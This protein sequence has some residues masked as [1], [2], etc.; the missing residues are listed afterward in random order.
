MA[1][2]A[3]VKTISPDQQTYLQN[4]SKKLACTFTMADEVQEWL[5][6]HACQ[7][8]GVERLEQIPVERFD[9]VSCLLFSLRDRVNGYRDERIRNDH[10]WLIQTFKGEID[11][12]LGYPGP[13]FDL[14]SFETSLDFRLR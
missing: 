13:E 12:F 6:R 1:A 11:N 7:L 3:P 9:D 8:A 14:P 2:P 4:V 5:L 10:A